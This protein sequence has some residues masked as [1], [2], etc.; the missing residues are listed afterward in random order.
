MQQYARI[1]GEAAAKEPPLQANFNSEDL[2][3]STQTKSVTQHRNSTRL[4]TFFLSCSDPSAGTA[5]SIETLELGLIC[6]PSTIIREEPFLEARNH[7][8]ARH[9][10]WR[11]WLRISILAG[12]NNLWEAGSSF[13]RRFGSPYRVV[14]Q[15]TMGF[16][17]CC[18]FRIRCSGPYRPTC[19]GQI[20]SRDHCY[21]KICWGIFGPQL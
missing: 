20:D 16:V 8:A 6:S 12:Y 19:A 18:S 5:M 7:T 15:L 1:P 3:A 17:R 11:G 4:G 14:S 10:D 13:L 21:M 2:V 9:P